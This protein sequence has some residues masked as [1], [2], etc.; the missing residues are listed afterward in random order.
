MVVWA[1][2]LT[3]LLTACQEFNSLFIDGIPLSSKGNGVTLANLPVNIVDRIEVY[4]GVVPASL[5]SDALGGAIN[6]ITKS[7]VKNYLD[8]SYGQGSFG[9]HKADLNAQYVFPKSS[10]FIRPSVGINYSKNNYEMKGVEIWNPNTSEFET[11]NLKRFHDDYFSN[12]SQLT[13]GVS[14]I[15]RWADL[16]S[17]SASCF[18]SDNELQTGSVQSVVYGMATRENK[19]YKIAGQ[20]QKEE[21]PY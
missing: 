8:A 10:L 14:P 18:S 1:L 16:F 15:R 3:L 19:S 21:P 6:I 5:G 13:V 2:I 9:T 12:L 4:K 11:A 20:Y 7:T 17:V